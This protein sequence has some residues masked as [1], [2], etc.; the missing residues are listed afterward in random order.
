MSGDKW[1]ESGRAIKNER[2]GEEVKI[3]LMEH[4]SWRGVY[5]RPAP[6]EN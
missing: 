2:R 6:L 3:G 5:M 4:N 1:G